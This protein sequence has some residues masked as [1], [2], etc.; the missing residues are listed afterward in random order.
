MI[1]RLEG[2]ILVLFGLCLLFALG[3]GVKSTLNE[4]AMRPG[5]MIYSRTYE[6]N[7]N[8]Y[9]V[10]ID[11]TLS[12]KGFWRHVELHPK[13]TPSWVGISG[14]QFS[15]RTDKWGWIGYCGMPDPVNGFNHF[16]YTVDPPKWVPCPSDKDK[17]K[18]F[19]ET[20]IIR[21]R[22]WLDRAILETYDKKHLTWERRA[23]QVQ[24]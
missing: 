24:T 2:V 18:P 8:G 20:D 7:I 19:S 15:K 23:K 6:G 5:K 16:D 12:S 13:G 9:E 1:R 10:T 14:H 4:R 22:V 3:Y 11:E 17:L 21:A